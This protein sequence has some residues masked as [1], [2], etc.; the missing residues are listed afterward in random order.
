MQSNSSA[1]FVV[2]N[3]DDAKRALEIAIQAGTDVTLISAP[4]A[5]SLLGPRTF[6]EMISAAR[7]D[8]PCEHI[9]VDAVLDCGDTAGPA[10]RA[11]REGSQHI[12]TH[13]PDEIAGKISEMARA[14]GVTLSRGT[15]PST[16][17][18]GETAHG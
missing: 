12:L 7:S 4:S 15:T 16:H 13:A 11:I 1:T 3:L 17:Q 2:H 10:L 18:Q 14:S 9:N 5:A 6:N 8:V